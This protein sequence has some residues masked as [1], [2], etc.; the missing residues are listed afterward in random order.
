MLFSK[1]GVRVD[2]RPGLLPLLGVVAALAIAAPQAAAQT[3]RT[4]TGT[5]N[6]GT[7]VSRWFRWDRGLTWSD[8]TAPN[9]T[10]IAFIPDPAINTTTSG[11]ITSIIEDGP[12]QALGI[13]V[14][15]SGTF[16]L[17][18]TNANRVLTLGTNGITLES[19]AGLF[20]IGADDSGGRLGPIINLV[21][22]TQTWRNDSATGRLFVSTAITRARIDTVST[23]TNGTVLRIAG[24]GPIDI[25]QP[26]TGS[27]SREISIVKE[28]SGLLTLW[29]VAGNDPST[30]AGGFTLRSGTV[31]L[32][33]PQALGRST[34]TIESGTLINTSGSAVTLSQTNAQVWNGNFGFRGV[35][36][37]NLGTG[38]VTLG[39]APTVTVASSTLTVGGTITGGFGLTKAGEGTLRLTAA[40][41]TFSGTTRIDAGI[42][43]VNNVN[44]ALRNTVVDLS[45]SGTLANFGTAPVFGGLLNYS[46]LTLPG[47][48]T[49]LTLN[50]QEGQIQTYDVLPGGGT[51][52][53]GLT[54][55]GPG[56]MIFNGTSSWTGVTRIEGGVLQVEWLANAGLAS[57]LGTS[58]TLQLG[59]GTSVGTLRYSGT[60]AHSTN[61]VINLAGSA[62]GGG[63]LDASGSGPVSFL[64]G[65][66]GVAGTTLTLSGSN[67]GA[68]Y[69][70]SVTGSNVTKTG[71][72]TWVFGTNS[73]T[74]QLTVEQGTIVAAINA[75]GG[76]G[77]SSALG[78]ENGP[79]PVVGLASASGTAALLAANGVT[80]ARVIEVAALG[81]GDQEVVLGGSGVGTATFDGGSAFRLGRGVTLAADPGGNVRFL[82]PTA[83]WQQQDGSADPAVAVTIGTPTATGTVT[84]ET[85]LPDS[86]TAVT[87]RQG[88][89]RL[90]VSSTFTGATPVTVGS[91]AD[92]A[93]L[94]LAGLG[95]TVQSLS[96]GGTAG[97]V[98]P[99][100]GS[101]VLRLAGVGPTVTVASGSGHRIDAPIALDAT[102]TFAVS[103]AAARLAVNGGIADGVSGAQGLAKSGSGTLVL[104]ALNTYTGTTS[105]AGG[106]IL[107]SG[108]G[109]IASS[110]LID[111]GAA[112]AIVFNRLDDYGGAYDGKL[113]GSGL[114][115]VQSGSLTLTGLNTFAGSSGV[116]SGAVLQLDGQ[117][118]NTS[119][120]VASGATLMGSGT[121]LGTTTIA[122]LH[123]PGN[124]PGIQTL[125]N[126]TY[127]S[128]A[129][130]EWELWNNTILNTST[131][132]DYD[133][134]LLTGD[135]DF[136]GAT[137]FNLVFTGSA[138][139]SNFSEV[140]WANSFWDTDREWLVYDVAGTT[141]GFGSLSLVQTNWQDSTG[142]DFTTARSMASFRLEK[143]PSNDVYLVYSAIPEPGTLAL[144]GIGLAAAA[145]AARRR[146]RCRA[147]EK[148]EA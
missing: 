49:R 14:A 37:L 141:T 43:D 113:T 109:R 89:L 127:T 25:R 71:P 82:T 128:G 121:I 84:F 8:N 18:A 146:C 57:P 60:G 107:V 98:L 41:N 103:S 3:I 10:S 93:T 29:Q 126:L 117:I 111:V 55:S 36:A 78:K 26:I 53:I 31:A 124:S 104:E 20:R 99:G 61:R 63:V 112:G 79:I 33:Y 91:A 54:K 129:S 102:T 1:S 30:F 46:G 22:G 34:F 39:A 120:D 19:T 2:T 58:G 108:S 62:G 137:A 66:T 125:G 87:V 40:S 69:I 115:S 148:P 123:R 13:Q 122:G 134:V 50:P 75:P 81:S 70:T 47:T 90:A 85:R 65:V 72:G 139:P 143:R 80:I 28:D 23:A 96:F 140:A 21:S 132:P 12:S 88:T 94:D 138:S 15:Y 77:T 74:G 59:T 92:S 42:L 144:A 105:I 17:V 48:V 68:N 110:A 100:G 131:P 45:G 97:L 51:A 67:T 116:L 56:T 9:A 83:N 119:L 95:Q 6:Q 136:A 142:A 76:S 24:S 5:N 16:N 11:S 27:S 4:F 106:A 101:G 52:T 44:S 133:Q 147:A 73:F 7:P 35:N 114:M 135:L 32:N 145:W 38:M 64:G 86:I 130:V 118:N